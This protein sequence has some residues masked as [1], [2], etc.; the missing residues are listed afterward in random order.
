[1]SLTRTSLLTIAASLLFLGCSSEEPETENLS[2]F[3]LNSLEGIIAQSNVALD[4]D[5]SFDGG[6]SVRIETS[7]PITVPLI[8]LSDPDIENA[9][10]LY[11]AKLRTKDLAGKA[12]LEMWCHFPGQGEFFSRDLATPITGDVD[13]STEE[14][15][16]F[17]KK[18]E[19][20]DLVKLNVVITGSGTVWIDDIKLYKGPL[21]PRT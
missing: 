18:G 11:Q 21:E 13:W 6:G 8:E 19:N 7:S 4:S 5:I 15:P 14:T 12:Y 16:F 3:P 17:L 1:M 9:V 2:A 20:P 10:L